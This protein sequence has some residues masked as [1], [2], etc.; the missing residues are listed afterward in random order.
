M[1]FI[2]AFKKGRKGKLQLQTARPTA[3]SEAG[4]NLPGRDGVGRQF[5]LK[6]DGNRGTL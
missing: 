1:A 2:T 5:G 3:A 6:P 4:G